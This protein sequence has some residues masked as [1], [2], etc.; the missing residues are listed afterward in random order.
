MKYGYCT[1]FSTNPHFQVGEELISMIKD[2]GFSY[3]EFPLM[4]F[5][6]MSNSA[7][8]A[9]C[10][11][12][13]TIGL[14]SDVACNFFPKDIQLVGK[15]VSE[16]HI[17]SYLDVVLPRCKKLGI[18]KIILGSGP[19]RTFGPDQTRDQAMGQFVALLK[20]VILPKTK[21]EGILV[22][23]EPFARDYCNLVVSAM[24]GLELVT[25]LDDPGFALM[26]DLYHML[27]NG[28]SLETLPQCFH[29]IKHI[30]VAGVN[31]RV[32]LDSDTYIY[33]ALRMLAKLGYDGTLSFETE[34][35]PSG[36]SLKNT[37]E[38]VKKALRR[39]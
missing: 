14:D 8:E 10:T 36:V 17:S 25:E 26:V 6:P 1:G 18:G 11:H 16:Q 3:V 39:N 29:A 12:V 22:C 13:T 37:L 34:L 23:I 31:R 19:S 5:W 38:K 9:L 21:K 35:P 27:C 28:E 4:N 20:E 24:E 30:H 15:G 32:P 7:F 33:D 2:E